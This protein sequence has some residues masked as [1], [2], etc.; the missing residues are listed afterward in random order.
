MLLGVLDRCRL[1]AVSCL[2]GLVAS[3]GFAATAPAKD[4]SSK[5]ELLSV[6]TGSVEHASDNSSDSGQTSDANQGDAAQHALDIPA[7]A[8]DPDKLGIS[9]VVEIDSTGGPIF[10]GSHAYN[11]FLRDHEVILT[12]DDGPLRAYTRRVLAALDAHCSR[13]TFFMV[14]RMAVAD[15][16]MV[17]EVIAAGH[18]V[19]SHTFNHR[20][21]KTIGLLKA[22]SDFELGFSAVTKA[23]GQPI[24]PL[25]RFP[26]LSESRQVLEHLKKRNIASFFIDIDSKDY[27]TRNS[28]IAFKRIM[29]QL[30]VTHKGIILMHDIQP[31]TAGMIKKLLDTLHDQG[32]KLVHVV[33][34]QTEPTMVEFDVPAAQAL[35]AKGSK[36]KQSPLSDRSLT[37]TA[38]PKEGAQAATTSASKGGAEPTTASNDDHLPWTKPAAKPRRAPKPA[39]RPEHEQLPWQS[40]TFAN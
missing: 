15:P 23:A 38:P 1:L 12:F 5:P 8:K 30:N 26:Y 13:A 35:A 17:R 25:F 7:C 27:Q 14:G 11:S 39:A 32:Y 16:A 28:D 18:T 6:E 29:S 34:K 31:S 21:L 9:R 36:A 2:I 3:F 24:A 4:G 10:G 40:R 37:W 19:G 22:R 33:P 20:N